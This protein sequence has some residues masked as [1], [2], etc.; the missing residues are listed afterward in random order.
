LNVGDYKEEEHLAIYASGNKNNI[1]WKEKGAPT[2]IY[3]LKGIAQNIFRLAGMDP[4]FKTEEDS[5]I[6]YN[7]NERIAK[8]AGV[9][10]EKLQAFSVKQPVIWI[11]IYW[12]VFMQQAKVVKTAIRAISRYPEVHRDISMIINKNTSWTEVEKITWSA[13]IQKLKEIKLFDIFESDK[14]GAGK[15]SFAISFTFADPEK[16]MTDKEIDA[17][18]N[19]LISAYEKQLG[20][21]IRKA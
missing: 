16:T 17:M 20:A 6:V 14:L 12:D 10:N 19:T 7:N 13:E 15:K 5:V 11:D 3:F 21:E 8:L 4:V 18:M 1:S 9:D 2:D